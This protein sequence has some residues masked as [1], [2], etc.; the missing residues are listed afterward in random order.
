MR[1]WEMST[2]EYFGDSPLWRTNKRGSKSRG[3]SSSPSSHEDQGATSLD[4]AALMARRLM[5]RRHPDELE[6]LSGSALVSAITSDPMI[7]EL[8]KLTNRL[9][10]RS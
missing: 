5:V 6:D 2:Q 10:E 1:C 4:Q 8:E 7:G 3:V 9:R